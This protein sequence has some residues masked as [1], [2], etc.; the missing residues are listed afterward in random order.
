M[1]RAEAVAK[2]A[3]ERLGIAPDAYVARARRRDRR[4]EID[5]PERAW[6]GEVVSPAGARRPTTG[7]PV[8]W[9]ATAAVDDVAPLLDRLG[10]GRAAGCTRPGLG[11]G[12]DPRPA[13]PRLDRGGTPR[14]GRGGAA[15]G[16]C[17]RVGDRPREVRRRGC[18]TTGSCGAGCRASTGRSWSSTRP[19]AWPR[20]GGS[21]PGPPRRGWWPRSWSGVLRPARRPRGDRNRR[22]GR[23]RPVPR[24]AVGRH[25][26]QG[27]RR[28]PSRRRDRRRGRGHRAQGRRRGARAGGIRWSTRLGSAQAVEAAIDGDAAHRGPARG[29]APGR[30]RD[31]GGAPPRGAGRSAGSPR[32]CTGRAA[33]SGGSRTPAGTCRAGG[34]ADRWPGRGAGARGR[35]GGAA[36]AALRAAASLAEAAA[37]RRA[38]GAAR[39]RG[40]PRDRRPAGATPGRR[41]RCGR[42]WDRSRR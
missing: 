29:G 19:T 32:S 39:D 3:R 10:A 12:R 2:E 17:R 18:S 42:C 16:R 36:R 38:E 25:R 41:A 7:T 15:E 21:G 14:E 8:A 5:D 31:A 11:G 27:G 1:A 9:V 20:G 24:L 34:R 6:P 37:S 28:R 22:L 33:G 35:A 23:R 26:R 4:R 13:G 30:G 40:R